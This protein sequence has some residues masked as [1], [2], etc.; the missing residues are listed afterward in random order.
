M[1]FPANP[2]LGQQ[3]TLD[4]RVYVWSG[5]VWN[6]SA[7]GGSGGVGPP[8]PIGATGPQGPAGPPGPPGPPGAGSDSRPRITITAN[9][10][11]A[12]F[13]QTLN[14]ITLSWAVTDGIVLTQI[15]SEVGAL[16]PTTRTYSF[17]DQTITADKTYTLAYSLAHSGEEFTDSA[18]ANLLFRYKRYWG[19]LATTTP[20]D[21][22]ILSLTGEF[23]TGYNQTRIFNPVN[24]YLYFAW[25]TAFGALPRFKL[26]GLTNSAWILTARTFVNAFGH[27]AAYN[28]Y[29]SEYRHSGAEIE[30]EVL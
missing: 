3:H 1:S 25:P 14:N 15:L 7:A 27:A 10:A 17:A 6:L 8:G 29:R 26:N 4:G 16:P 19:A 13:G 23:S 11:F 20:T 24:T 5:H 28:I 9:P 21:L 2:A 22:D 30:V 12:E 18:I